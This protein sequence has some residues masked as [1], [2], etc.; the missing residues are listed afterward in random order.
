MFY[1][2]LYTV[3][4]KLFYHVANAD[5]KIQSA[6]REKLHELVVSKWKPLESS[7]DKFGTDNAE[8]IE[9][10]FDFEESES[11]TDDG[12]KEFEEFYKLF[13]EKFTPE[14]ASN[15]LITAKAVADAY[16]GINKAEGEAINKLKH[17]LGN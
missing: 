15:I 1:Q 9:F 12:L 11:L 10:A 4:G 3:L 13:K 17:L 6:E 14:I 2:D 7:N 8:I 16:G 5:E